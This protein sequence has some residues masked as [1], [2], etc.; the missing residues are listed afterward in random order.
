MVLGKTVEKT[1][2]IAH[3]FRK[4]FRDQLSIAVTAAFAFLIAL[5]WKDAIFESVNKIISSFNLFSNIYL[6]RILSAIA[7]TIIS[8]L[9]ILIVSRITAQK[10][11]EN[12]PSKPITPK[13]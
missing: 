8:V 6:F 10:K 13:N 9:G 12:S 7:V 5:A 11:I 3:I 2:N 4:E 1:R